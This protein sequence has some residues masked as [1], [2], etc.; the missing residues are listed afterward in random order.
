MS[1]VVVAILSTRTRC[2]SR[3]YVE[4]RTKRYLLAGRAQKD[5]RYCSEEYFGWKT[6]RFGRFVLAT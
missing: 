2:L 4:I 3:I 1:V 5:A 6:D